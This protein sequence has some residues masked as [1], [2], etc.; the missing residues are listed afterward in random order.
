MDQAPLPNDGSD[1]QDEHDSGSDQGSNDGGS[2]HG[3]QDGDLDNGSSGGGSD[4]GSNDGGAAKGLDKGSNE[5]DAWKAIR[6]KRCVRLCSG[7]VYIKLYTDMTSGIALQIDENKQLEGITTFSQSTYVWAESQAFFLSGPES[8]FPGRGKACFSEGTPTA[9]SVD[10]QA[11]TQ[12]LAYGV[13]EPDS[14]ARGNAS[15]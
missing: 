5:D 8:C 6:D 1:K 14:P 11:A 12:S 15:F 13:P 10:R 2:D 4:K 3:S 9:W 7:D